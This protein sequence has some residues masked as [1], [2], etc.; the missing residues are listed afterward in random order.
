[1]PR[2]RIRSRQCT[3]CLFVVQVQVNLDEQTVMEVHMPKECRDQQ[4]CWQHFAHDIF[5]RPYSEGMRHE[6]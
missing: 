1:M 5:D 6:H 4:D 3:R 2:C